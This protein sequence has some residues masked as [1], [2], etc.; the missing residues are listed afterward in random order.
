MRSD[1][2]PI[3]KCSEALSDFLTITPLRIGKAEVVS[4][5]LTGSTILWRRMSGGHSSKRIALGRAE[6]MAKPKI[7]R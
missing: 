6:G 5:I 7:S 4:S 3:G 2:Q 1:N